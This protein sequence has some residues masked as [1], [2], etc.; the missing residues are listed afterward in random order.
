[1]RFSGGS[2]LKLAVTL[3]VTGMLIGFGTSYLKKPQYMSRATLTMTPVPP[4]AQVVANQLTEMIQREQ[5]GVMS[6]T[7][8]SVMINDP[9]L[10]LYGEERKTAPLEDV[11]DEMRNHILVDYVWLPTRHAS[12]FNV[13][14]TYPDKVKAQQTVN[15]LVSAFVEQ[16][17]E[18]QRGDR[19]F[20]EVLEV[21]DTASLP[22]N[23]VSPYRFM[24][25]LSGSVLGF[26]L[27]T[28]IA[29]FR[30][31]GHS[32]SAPILATNE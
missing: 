5:Q 20:G 32:P 28:V 26:L 1:M 9:R 4:T 11:I 7:K 14:F 16:N 8:L 10:D 30:R 18:M 27:A 21:V 12:A 22:V 19:S 3:G 23:P 24:Y 29:L 25:A 17:Q 13:R 2:F 6:R 31:V 15:A